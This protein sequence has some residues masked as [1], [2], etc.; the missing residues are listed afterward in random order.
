MVTYY[1]CLAN[2]RIIFVPKHCLS[3]LSVFKIFKT[4]ILPA[5]SCSCATWCFTLRE[6]NLMTVFGN[7]A[8]ENIWTSSSALHEI[9]R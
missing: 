8:V 3:Q 4:V 1:C 5:V 7:G 9:M 6:D 2:N